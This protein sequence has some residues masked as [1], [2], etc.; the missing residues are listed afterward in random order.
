MRRVIACAL[1]VCCAPAGA[2]DQPAPLPDP[3]TLEYALSLAAGAHP[4]LQQARAL[5]ERARAE[6]RQVE[7]RTGVRADIEASALWVDPAPLSPDTS[8]NDSNAKLVVR[9]RL[10]DFGRSRNR[11][12][13][14]DAD[15]KGREWLYIDA[16][17]GRR[18]D[19]MRR[20]FDVLLADLRYSRDN[21]AMAVAYVDLDRLRKKR[22][23]GEVSDITVLKADSEY[24]TIRRARYASDAARR[25]TRARLAEALNRPGDLP[26]H[27][28]EPSLPENARALPAL[29][30]LTDQALRDN[31]VL[32]AMHERLA[33]ARERVQAARAGGNPVVSGLLEGAEYHRLFGSRDRWRAGVTLEVPLFTG[34]AVQAEV[35]RAL[36]DAHV[37]EARFARR[38]M[39]VRQ[40]VLDTWERI[41]VLRVQRQEARALADYRDLYLD[42]SRALYQLELR[43]DLGDSMVQLSEA[44][45]RRAE[46]RYQLAL[47]WA[48][49]DALTGRPVLPP[50]KPAPKPR[51]TK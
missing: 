39:D 10:Y 30:K 2:D 12:A 26:G 29:D 42:R 17:R 37:L 27:L 11:L 8:H 36:A 48:R 41:Q 49:L 45:L 51:Q 19:I 13:A 47:S 14:A 23:L 35:A 4:D 6:R 16:R 44:R 50:S 5:L 9:K 15:V 20:Y 38:R 7:A 25:I 28:A 43:T 31:P 32:R 21:E 22:K 40:A 46:T 24:Q 34:G 3:L 1:A 18:I 33:A